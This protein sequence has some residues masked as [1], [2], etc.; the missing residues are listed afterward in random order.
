MNNI[1]FF[2][3]QKRSVKKKGEFMITSECKNFNL[4]LVFRK[5][6]SLFFELTIESEF[7]CYG[8]TKTIYLQS[9][10]F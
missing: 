5:S 10:M 4:A 7:C 6:N 2:T 9:L 1:I 3:D 8:L